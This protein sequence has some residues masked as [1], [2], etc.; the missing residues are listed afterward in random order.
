VLQFTPWKL[1]HLGACRDAACTATA[2]VPGV[3]AW[4]HG[5]VLGAHCVRCCLGFMA[6]LVVVGVMDVG[7]MALVALAITAE[8]VLPRPAL[9]AR[10]AGLLSIA[11]GAWILCKPS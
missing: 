9:V 7:L 11:A 10:A 2:P 1:R 4:R 8:R 5:L 3:R 6:A